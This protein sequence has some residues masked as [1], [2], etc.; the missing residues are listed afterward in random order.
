[1]MERN[2][3]VTEGWIEHVVGRNWEIYWESESS[4]D[5]ATDANSDM[6]TSDCN[7][8]NPR[9]RRRLDENNPNGSDSVSICVEENEEE[10]SEDDEDDWYAGYI[11]KFLGFETAN[12]G[13]EIKSR[14]LFQ[15]LFVDDEELYEMCVRPGILR[16]CSRTWV[17]RSLAL[18]GA[19]K[20]SLKTSLDN[21]LPND[22][23]RLHDEGDLR[24]ISELL[25]QKLK[26]VQNLS[27]AFGKGASKANLPEW[28][29]HLRI[30]ELIHLLRQQIYLRSWLIPADDEPVS[31]Y[32]TDDE[33]QPPP[34]AFINFLVDNLESAARCC[35][36]YD[37]CYVLLFRIFD[38][39][40][41]EQP[42]SIDDDLFKLFAD[43]GRQT[44]SEIVSLDPSFEAL[45]RRRKNPMSATSNGMGSPSSRTRRN[46][47][48]RTTN[49]TTD[50]LAEDELGER[51][52][53]A[54]VE[55][56]RSASF[57]NQL[58]QRLADD[59]KRWFSVAIGRILRALSIHVVA[60]VINWQRRS[61]FY[62]GEILRDDE[63]N[64]PDDNLG[65]GDDGSDA[66]QQSSDQEAT[67]VSVEDIEAV[68]ESAKTDRVVSRFDVS[69][70][71]SRL[72]EK[73]QEISSFEQNSWSSIRQILNEEGSP[74][75]PDEDEIL[76]TLHLLIETAKRQ[77]SPVGNVEPFG[78]GESPLTRRM[79]DDAAENRRWFLDLKHAE[80]VRERELFIESLM[81]RHSKL[82]AL[83]FDGNELSG[84]AGDKVL[85]S[86]HHRVQ[87]LSSL[88]QN[89]AALFDQQKSVLNEMEGDVL[90]MK[91]ALTSI[92]DELQNVRILSVVEEMVLIRMDVGS[93]LERAQDIMNQ[94]LPVFDDILEIKTGLDRLLS[95]KSPKR[96]EVMSSLRA[97]V[98]ADTELRQFARK[99][100][101]TFCEPTV[102]KTNSL[103]S[104]CAAWKERCDSIFAVLRFHGNPAASAENSS[105]AFIK[106][107]GMVDLK[108]IEDLLQEYS[109]LETSV[110][111]DFQSLN[112]AFEEC[113]HWS[114]R[115]TDVLFSDDTSLS[116]TLSAVEAANQPEGRPK[117][118]IL[119]PTR[120]ILDTVIDVLRWHSAVKVLVS[121]NF[122][123][124]GAAY[125]LLME[126][127]ELIDLYGKSR[128]SAKDQYVLKA[129]DLREL[130]RRKLD[131]RKPIRSFSQVKLESHAITEKLLRKMM[132]EN[133]DLEEGLPLFSLLLL[134][135]QVEAER[136]AE[137]AVS[138]NDSKADLSYEKA[139]SLK[140]AMPSME[141][142]NSHLFSRTP[143]HWLSE[144]FR[145]VDEAEKANQ[146][147]VTTVNASKT[148]LRDCLRNT[149]GVRSHA[150]ALKDHFIAIR[151]DVIPSRILALPRSVEGKLD[152][153]IKLF[154]WLV[155]A[156]TVR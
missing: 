92:L 98:E 117:G 66:S 43:G 120:Q 41:M 74:H 24:K 125:Q 9:K 30:R 15:V 103:Y 123:D 68:L 72:A 8:E 89:N 45:K 14:P 109:G 21:Q 114:E 25:E 152:K 86:V 91:L 108:R 28:N 26:P 124:M 150:T 122:S 73:L 16:P 62:L 34:L 29:E 147:I 137:N 142:T 56:F 59:D 105:K 3:E 101:N 42:L 104:T 12:D 75:C 70:V 140:E 60:P 134:S 81:S 33:D 136:F 23:R 51:F 27:K 22:T 44:L 145:L 64:A 110:E 144:F 67:W 36:W 111:K 40:E 79:L 99:D 131:S 11:K 35:L 76:K 135:W 10:E 139:L 58:V 39:K 61:E 1:M 88:L 77:D 90:D 121:G 118:I 57:V 69:S 37:Q 50:F 151:R 7:M 112:A 46:K 2:D 141:N 102:N 71:T 13:H 115:I 80:S 38:S 119:Y 53:I 84:D 94:T 113:G 95:A 87:A 17:K 52:M 149:D 143:S 78:K 31:C 116:D 47:R 107:T 128:T 148:F 97:C 132:D 4:S 19:H 155:S 63:G 83:P 20:V 65:V 156:C 18:L 153:E 138:S 85:E 55:R 154:A 126:G 96:V 49:G 106:N 146:Q 6:N 54:D 133:R 48:R 127:I 32:S 100:L 5:H 82:P 93:W 129:D 130:L